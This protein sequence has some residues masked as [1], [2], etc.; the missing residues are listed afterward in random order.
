MRRISILNF[1]GGVGKTTLATNLAAALARRGRKT[2]LIDCDLQHNASLLLAERPGPT[3]TQVI[4]QEAQL[5][6]AIVMA[7]ENLALVPADL[8]LNEAANYIAA[9][10]MRAYHVLRNATRR[11]CGFDFLFFDHAPS[12]TP[13]TE[14]ALLASDEIMVPVELAPFAVQGL[15]QMIRK[16]EATLGSLDHELTLSII[17]FKLDHRYAMTAQYLASLHETFGKHVAWPVR[18]DA[19]ISRAQ[20]L[21]Q[22]VFEYDERSKA[23]ADFAKLA[24]MLDI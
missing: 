17:P 6:A 4:R 21:G 1:K 12:Y 7:R 19:V 13:V 5:D 10:G 2:L 18:T 3:L 8:D 24:A 14:A 15:L 22:T 20:S 9:S 16:L 11:L 23:A